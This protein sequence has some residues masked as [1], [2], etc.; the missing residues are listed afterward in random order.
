MK[1]R[2]LVEKPESYNGGAYWVATPDEESFKLMVNIFITL[3]GVSHLWTMYSQ[4]GMF[5]LELDEL[6]EFIALSEPTGFKVVDVP[7]KEQ[8]KDFEKSIEDIG[9]TLYTGEHMDNFL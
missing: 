3:F 8:V 1:L 2:V 6:N 4:D 7:H 5:I 9:E